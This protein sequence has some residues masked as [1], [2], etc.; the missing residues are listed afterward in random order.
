MTPPAISSDPT[1]STAK[2]MSV[3]VGK[4]GAGMFSRWPVASAFSTSRYS[5][6][7]STSQP[8]RPMTVMRRP[9]MKTDGVDDEAEQQGRRGD[10]GEQGPER[11]AGDMD[12]GRGASAAGGLP[13]A[14]AGNAAG[15]LQRVVL[16]V[17]LAAPVEEGPDDGDQADHE[18]EHP[19]GLDD[20]RRGVGDRL[21]GLGVRGRDDLDEERREQE[22]EGTAGG[23]E[24]APGSGPACGSRA[25]WGAS[26]AGG[27]PGGPAVAYRR[28][29]QRR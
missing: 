11:G 12:A 21:A 25:G 10:R 19:E 23:Q 9:A 20:D 6:R 24:Q 27:R 14:T 29:T 2:T 4:R 3:P 18:G 28:I 13:P 26:A 22:G 8:S 17:R 7:A 16:A 15:G 1:K 5:L